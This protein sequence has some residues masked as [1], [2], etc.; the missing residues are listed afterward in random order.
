MKKPIMAIA[1]LAILFIG[2]TKDKSSGDLS[3]NYT[4]KCGT[5]PGVPVTPQPDQHVNASN[6]RDA[7]Q[8]CREKGVPNKTF[9]SLK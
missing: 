6:E 4:C 8:L 5:P 3:K 2:C 9:C 7:A 1:T